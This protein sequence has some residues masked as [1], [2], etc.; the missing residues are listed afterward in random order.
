MKLYDCSDSRI[1]LDTVSCANIPCIPLETR[2]VSTSEIDERSV[3]D[4]YQERSWKFTSGWRERYTVTIPLP[5]TDRF[6]ASLQE[7]DAFL[8]SY[9]T[10]GRCITIESSGG[11]KRK[12]GVESKHDALTVPD[13]SNG[14]FELFGDRSQKIA[15][16]SEF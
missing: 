8:L 9:T 13:S 5:S 11:D 1:V 2:P 6:T 7:H 14:L 16:I 3:E 15:K 10:S 12:A 4:K